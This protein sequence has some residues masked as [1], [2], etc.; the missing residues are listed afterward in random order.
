MASVFTH[1]L[2][3]QFM[4]KVF[5]AIGNFAVYTGNL[6]SRFMSII[7][8]FLFATKRFLHSERVSVDA[9]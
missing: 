9:A 1:Q 7:S 3:R 5:A 8:S 4:E 6:D 2:S